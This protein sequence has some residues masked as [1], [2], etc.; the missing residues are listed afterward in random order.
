MKISLHKTLSLFQR[1]NLVDEKDLAA[2]TWNN[3]QSGSMKKVQNS[4]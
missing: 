1:Y 3:E 4:E 2:V